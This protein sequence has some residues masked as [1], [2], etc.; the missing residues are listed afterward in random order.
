[1]VSR[2]EAQAVLDAYITATWGEASR[3]NQT[4]GIEGIM[5]STPPQQGAIQYC[6]GVLWG[7]SLRGLIQR[8][9]LDRSLG[10]MPEFLN[11]KRQRLERA[12]AL[13]DDSASSGADRSLDDDKG[14]DRSKGAPSLMQY[15]MEF[16]GHADWT[17]LCK[18]SD[19]AITLLEAELEETMQGM[20]MLASAGAEDDEFEY[21][22]VGDDDPDSDD[23]EEMVMLDQ[24]D[25]EAFQR[26]ATAIGCLLA[27]AEALVGEEVGPLPRG[28]D[29]GWVQH[30]VNSGALSGTRPEQGRMVASKLLAPIQRLAEVLR[31]RLLPSKLKSAQQGLNELFASAASAATK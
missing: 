7:Y 1:V 20:A 17:A 19:P 4:P 14:A 2:A 21:M 8:L 6:I 29:S 3:F 18:P 9:V 15:A 27:D 30:L 22:I 11:D 25:W 23:S 13:D 24:E 5:V 31:N 10:T 28:A 12:L 16:F 26:R